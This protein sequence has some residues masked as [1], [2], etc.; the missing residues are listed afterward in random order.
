M[1]A[2]LAVSAFLA[3]VIVTGMVRKFALSRGVLDMPKARSSHRIATPT[4][5]GVAIALV[6]SCWFL[7]LWYSGSLNTTVLFALLGGL[8]VSALGYLDDC[9]GLSVA[10]RLV[11]QFGVAFWAVAQLNGS[12]ILPV[13]A[14]SFALKSIAYI[15][16]T[17][18]VTWTINVFNFMD[19]LDGLA[20]SQTAFMALSAA[21]LI[22]IS[23]SP[24]GAAP[25]ALVVGSACAGFLVWNWHPARIFLGDAGSYYLGYVVAVLIIIDTQQRDTAIHTWLILGAVFFLDATLT[26]IRRLVRRAPIFVAHRSHAYQQLY[27]RWR[28]HSW[29]TA[30]IATVNVIW[31]FPWAWLVV[32]HPQ[33]SPLAAL[34]A[35]VPVAALAFAVGAGGE[36]KV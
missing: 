3:V 33:W 22:S 13:I 26:L 29:I 4:G 19:G 1:S 6:A 8:V 35:L 18:G 30:G 24:V 9:F 17:L 11:V 16:V 32:V 36:E 31:L 14:D 25:V 21:F 28:S 2:W 10:T 12:L 23:G 20:A 5:G 27:H 15:A 7:M 34:I